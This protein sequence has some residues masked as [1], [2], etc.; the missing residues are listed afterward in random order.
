MEKWEEGYY[1]TA[2]AGALSG[3]ALVVMSKGTP[4]TQQSYKVC[5]R[6]LVARACVCA[7]AHVGVHGR[8]CKHRGTICASVGPLCKNM[9]AGGVASAGEWRGGMSARQSTHMRTAL[10]RDGCAQGTECVCAA[11]MRRGAGQVTPASCP[12]QHPCFSQACPRRKCPPLV[13]VYVCRCLRR[14][15]TPSPS[16]GSTRSGRRASM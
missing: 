6:V 12:H 13:S 9:G 4:Y 1:I 8:H 14:C 10:M 5:M 7:C 3:C 11:L 2:M 16:S 15:R